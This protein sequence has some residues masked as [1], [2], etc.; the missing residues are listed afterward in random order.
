MEKA[1]RRG[2]EYLYSQQT[3]RSDWEGVASPDAYK[4]MENESYLRHEYGGRT[5]LV[6]LALLYAGESPK[7][8]RIRK[9]LAAIRRQLPKEVEQAPIIVAFDV[10]GVHPH[11][12][13]QVLDSQGICVRGG[14]HCAEPLHRALGL[15]ATTRASFWLYNST[16]DV[17]RLADGLEAV[18]R[19]FV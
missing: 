1:I 16:A 2:V 6:V 18:R 13:A 17:D 8:E 11:D 7:D 19:L 9:T 5:A 10:A 14:H 3:P 12:V 15:Q 4:G